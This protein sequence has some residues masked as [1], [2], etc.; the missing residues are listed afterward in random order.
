MQN[1]QGLSFLP[2]GT[3]LVLGLVSVAVTGAMCWLAWHRTG[4]HKWTGILELLRFVLVCLVVATL[5]QPEWL[6]TRPPDQSSTL[7]VLW[8]QSNS[9]ETRD[10]IDNEDISDQPKSRSETIKPLISETIWKPIDNELNVVFEPF[11]SQLTPAT[12]ATD[13]NA[14]LSQVLENHSNRAFR[15]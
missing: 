15:W 8:D 6:E 2:T 4:Y 9:M 1:H 11:S 13:L 7:V 10:I 3:I 12:E 5:C 14:G